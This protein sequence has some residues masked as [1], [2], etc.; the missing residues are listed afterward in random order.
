ME[1]P[2]THK[3]SARA[4]AKPEGGV[5]FGM[6]PLQ[7]EPAADAIAA[8]EGVAPPPAHDAA[9]DYDD[10][11]LIFHVSLPDI[12]CRSLREPPRGTR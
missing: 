7:A 2:E 9:A 4:D 5:A 10:P 6:T 3:P 11:V 1:A 8:N 12:A